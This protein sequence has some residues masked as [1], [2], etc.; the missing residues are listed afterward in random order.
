MEKCTKMQF[1]I[2]RDRAQNYHADSDGIELN[3][4]VMGETISTYR[5]TAKL[6]EDWMDEIERDYKG[7]GSK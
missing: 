2:S 3:F 6:P 1:E 4:R 5:E 7:R